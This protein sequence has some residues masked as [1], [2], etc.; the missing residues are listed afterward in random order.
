MI[1]SR[2]LP[3]ISD[4]QSSADL[5]AF[6]LASQCETQPV[7]PQVTMPTLLKLSWS[8]WRS[9][10]IQNLIHQDHNHV[11]VPLIC[12]GPILSFK[13]F[14]MLHPWHRRL[15]GRLKMDI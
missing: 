6:V 1:Q 13:Y 12:P 9:G 7:V 8:Y 15:G 14:G 5:K 11:L 2:F 4:V 10:R 3:S